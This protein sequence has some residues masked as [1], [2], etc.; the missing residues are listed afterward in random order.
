MTAELTNVYD[1]LYSGE[2]RAR[3]TGMERARR[4][5]LV[6]FIRHVARVEDVRTMLDYGAGSGLFVDLWRDIFPVAEISCAEISPIALAK[7]KSANGDVANRCFLIRDHRVQ[8]DRGD[9]DLIVS[10]EVMEHV[11]DLGAYLH[12]IFRLLRPGGVFV[13]T[14]PSANALSL[15]Q[16]Y[17]RMTGQEVPTPEG[18]R[19]WRWEDPTHFRRLKSREIE[20]LLRD[21]GFADVRFRFRSHMFSFLFASLP[22]LLLGRLNRRPRPS[23]AIEASQSPL[24]R[25]AI[26]LG[27]DHLRARLIGL[28]Y[29]LFRCLPNGASMLGCASKPLQ[30]RTGSPG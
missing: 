9:F 10:V 14:T 1:D 16:I 8:I 23:P 2:Y 18:Y 22:G 20:T 6:H 4:A 28:D 29:S 19:R 15:E 24:S 30:D 25:S 12:D 17:T 21:L 13:W 3:L 5:A 26:S 27:V 11:E 7:L